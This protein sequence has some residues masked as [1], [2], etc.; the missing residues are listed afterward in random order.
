MDLLLTVNKVQVKIPIPGLPQAV[1]E[2]TASLLRKMLSSADFK[3]RDAIAKAYLYVM[4]RST[5]ANP[6]DLWHHVIYRLYCDILKDI[7]QL[8]P[9]QSWVR[10]SG[11]ALELFLQGWYGKVLSGSGINITALPVGKAKHQTVQRL[12]LDR[13]VGGSKLDVILSESGRI[14]AGVHVK[15]SLAERISDDIPCSRALMSK[16]FWSPLWTLDVKSFPPPHGN[17]QNKG[18]LGSPAR[19][20]DKRKYIEEHG[21]FDNC[22]SANART[23]PSNGTTISGK[24]IHT[25]DLWNQPD[26]FALDA[27]A[28]SCMPQR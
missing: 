10:A 22:Y 24:V 20:S 26:R 17:L 13:S 28:R 14:F 27:I 6:S 16:G 15:A 8:D 7:G 23:I 2:E 21:D 19:P 18:E 4:L 25:L 12:G 9:K 5:G 3:N 1:Y 11:D